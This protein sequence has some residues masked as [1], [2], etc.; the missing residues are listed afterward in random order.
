MQDEGME[1]IKALMTPILVAAA[2]AALVWSAWSFFHQS[3][4]NEIVAVNDIYAAALSDYQNGIATTEWGSAER[5]TAMNQ[6][7]TL[8]EDLRAQYPDHPLSDEALF[9]IGDAHYAKGDDLVTGVQGGGIPNTEAAIRAYTQYLAEVDD[10]FS[11]AKGLLALGYANENAYFLT[12][13]VDYLNEAMN[14]YQRVQ[15]VAGDSF[16]AAEAKLAMAR[17]AEFQGR[18]DQARALYRE[19]VESRLVPVKMPTD[20]TRQSEIFKAQLNDAANQLTLGMTA[21]LALERLGVDVEEEYPTRVE[22]E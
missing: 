21:R 10:D 16:I 7:V 9:L 22:V 18:L 4:Q 3:K 11:E 5:A 15:D 12:N 19:V 8:A 17:N 20:E 1:R 6:V 2:V 14:T 13:D